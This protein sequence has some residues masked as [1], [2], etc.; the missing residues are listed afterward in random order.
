MRYLVVD[1]EQLIATILQTHL[2]RDGHE[3]TVAGDG[4]AAHELWRSADPAFDLVIS[5]VKLPGMSGIELVAAIRDGGDHVPCL[6]ISGH[7]SAHMLD[8]APDLEPVGVLAKPFSLAD[9][10]AMVVDLLDG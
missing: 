7:V 2:V 9:L 4:R 8:E 5:D 3:V 6:L 10:E 1:D